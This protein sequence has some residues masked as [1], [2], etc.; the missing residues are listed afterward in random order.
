MLQGLLQDLAAELQDELIDLDGEAKATHSRAAEVNTL[1]TRQECVS[2]A[3]ICRALTMI[4][5]PGLVSLGHHET[6][7]GRSI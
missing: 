3:G 7:S 1:L 4:R 2:P 5:L 6:D